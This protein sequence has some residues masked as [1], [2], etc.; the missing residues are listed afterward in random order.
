MHNDNAPRL[1]LASQ[2]AARRAMLKSAGVVF[3]VVASTIDEDAIRATMISESDC[4]EAADIA[5]VL[6]FETARSVA[7]AH[8]GCYV[9]GSDQV[10]ALGRH[11]FSKAATLAEARDNFDRLRGRTHELVSAAA[12]VR[13]DEVIWQGVD[14]AQLTMRRFSDAFLDDYLGR[15]GDRVLKTVGGYAIESDGLQFFDRIDG[16]YFTILG[17]PLLPVL[18][19]LRSHGVVAS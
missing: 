14:T 11:M 16:D 19:Q 9:L 15:V 5:A 10:L 1:I 2:S 13:N 4:H 8:P 12:L 7:L 3:D 17:M 18:H 6:A